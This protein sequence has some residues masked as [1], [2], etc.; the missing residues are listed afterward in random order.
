MSFRVVEWNYKHNKEECLQKLHLSIDLEFHET[1]K[2]YKALNQVLI[3]P[4]IL[5]KLCSKLFLKE[6]L[7]IGIGFRRSFQAWSAI[8]KVHFKLTTFG[9]HQDGQTCAEIA[10]AALMPSHQMC[11]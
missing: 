1:P 2:L 10:S 11:R 5:I 4:C 6:A 7:E 8:N 9:S 3:T